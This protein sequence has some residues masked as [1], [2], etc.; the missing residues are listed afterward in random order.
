MDKSYIAGF[1]DGEGSAIVITVRH[2]LSDERAT[3]TFRPIVSI[4]QKTHEVLENIRDV[5]GYGHIDYGNNKRQSKYVINSRGNIIRFVDDISPH[6]FLKRKQ[7]ELLKELAIF[8]GCGGRGMIT[9]ERLEQI[10]DF[11]DEIHRL[12]TFTRTNIALKY[13]K[14]DILKEYTVALVDEYERKRKEHAVELGRVQGNKNRFPRRIIE[15]A[16]GCGQ[17]FENLDNQGRPRQYVA[18]HN[19]PK[20]K[21][22]WRG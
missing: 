22:V 16:C 9:R 2:K 12:N 18:G 13:S 21:C 5:L 11:R 1:F 6:S 3:Y 8:K 17:K 4:S 15:C 7:L 20:G 19:T 14:E 10:I